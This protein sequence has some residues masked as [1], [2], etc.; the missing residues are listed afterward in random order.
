MIPILYDA[1]EVYFAS[2]G[3]GRLRDCISCVVTEERNGVYECDFEYPVNGQ[4][5]ERISLGKVIAVQY[6]DS[7]DVQPFDI[8]SCSKP[9]NGVVSFHAVHI[10]YRQSKLTVSGT[11][12]NSLAD[13]LAM[14]EN[15]TP[16]NPFTYET[17]KVSSG[18]LAAADGTPRSVK[19]VLGG[20][21][22]SILDTYGGEY[23]YNKFTV[24]LM[25]SRG[26][27]RGFT[28]RYG[29]NLLDY[30]DDTD[31]SE[32]YNACVPYWSGTDSNGDPVK[33][34]GD[35]VDSG[36]TSY[37]GRTECVPLDMTDK[38]ETQP[39]K[40]TLEAAA[41]SYMESN[42]V[43]LPAQTIKVNFIRLQDSTEYADYAALFECKL[44]DSV[45]VV[46][47]RYG[48]DGS[49]KIVKTVYNTLTERYDEMELGAL[50]ITL[51]QA[52]GLSK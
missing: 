50:P 44:C 48:M 39:T 33:V 26:V 11:N 43:N 16:A 15:A 35:Q 23:K 31:Y 45:R 19:S 12:I 38:F 6:D 46:F 2:N 41:L 29:V 51:S 52:L 1:E 30:T 34:K 22:G 27:D 14:L 20:S 49:F 32:S 24:S 25:T 18:Y 37:T 42:Q 9:I 47:P 40:A 3:L 13:A 5:Y 4:N 10:S 8:V 36:L 17:D 21:E 7:D 28:I